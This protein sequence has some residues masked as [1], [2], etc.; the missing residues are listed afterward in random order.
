MPPAPCSAMRLSL[1]APSGLLG[2]T[3]SAGQHSN[4]INHNVIQ[5]KIIKKKY[6]PRGWTYPTNKFRLRTITIY[7]MEFFFDQSYDSESPCRLTCFCDLFSLWQKVAL[8]LLHYPPQHQLHQLQIQANHETVLKFH[9]LMSNSKEKS[10]CIGLKCTTWDHCSSSQCL[11]T[12]TWQ[13]LVEYTKYH[14]IL[15][16]A[17][18]QLVCPVD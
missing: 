16:W 7:T 10:S 15:V 12:I 18:L 1:L 11:T 2:H 17:L 3:S 9:M 8:K 13:L 14:L 4:K 5:L 6:I